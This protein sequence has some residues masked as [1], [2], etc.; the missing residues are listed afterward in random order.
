MVEIN[1]FVLTERDSTTNIMKR[2]REACSRNSIVIE[3]WDPFYRILESD[4]IPVD[5]G[6]CSTH[7]SPANVSLGSRNV[8]DPALVLDTDPAM[9]RRVCSGTIRSMSSRYE[10]K[11]NK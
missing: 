7:S 11:I 9:K 1:A 4:G 6:G 3:V 2:M 8:E 10:K 5:G